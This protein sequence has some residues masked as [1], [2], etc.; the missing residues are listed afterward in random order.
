VRTK[1]M[2]GTVPYTCDIWAIARSAW[3][4]RQQGAA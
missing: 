4:R 3:L 2:V 1:I